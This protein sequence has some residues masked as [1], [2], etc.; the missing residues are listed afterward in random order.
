MSHELRT[1]LHGILSF[2]NFGINKS[3]KAT[4]EKLK[5]YFQQVERS[6]KTLL[7]LLNDLLD[8][9]KLEA[10]K[11]PFTFHRADLNIL[12]GTV[13]DEFSSLLAARNLTVKC[14]IP[15]ARTEVILD[16]VKVMQVVRN[17]LG[18]AL[19][20]SPDNATIG[21]SITRKADSVVV[22]VLDQGVG[23]A[24]EELETIFD[25]FIQSSKTKA[26]AGGTGLGLF[27]CREIVAAHKGH[28]W[29]E[30][31]PEG[32]ATFSI[33]IPIGLEETVEEVET[34]TGEERKES[35]RVVDRVM[36]R[37]V[38]KERAHAAA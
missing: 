38:K 21:L 15:E 5:G 33:E 16:S 31:R 35:R 28:I 8:L 32:G 25:K 1:P 2:A 13:A 10:G 36:A 9:A 12:L 18:N 19:K 24:E 6:G 7:A 37:T 26:G 30:N 29:V 27:V 14:D 34:K 20:F 4:P 3:G 11:M 17:L 22:S 23:V